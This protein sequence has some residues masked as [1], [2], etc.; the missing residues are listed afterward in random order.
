MWERKTLI[1]SNVKKTPNGKAIGLG[2]NHLH[3]QSK[4]AQREISF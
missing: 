4:N 3:F 2:S 1:H